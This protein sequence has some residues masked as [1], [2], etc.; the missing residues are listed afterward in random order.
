MIN[1][2][3]KILEIT[4]DGEL[5]THAKYYI[6]ANNEDINVETEGNWWFSDKI[7]NIPLSD[8]KEEDIVSWIEKEATVNGVCHITN[9]LENQ[10]NNLK[11]NFCSIY[12][13]D[14]FLNTKDLYNDPYYIYDFEGTTNKTSIEMKSRRVKK[15]TYPTTILPVSKIRNTDKAQLFVFNFTDA[16][17]YIEYDKKI[18]DTFQIR[19][20][21]TERF[22][23]VDKPKPH[24]C[25]YIKD[26]IEIKRFKDNAII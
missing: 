19:H 23:I 17:C 13:E 20:F 5:I 2:I 8:V 18:F 25:I 10:L 1:Y 14:D 4:T 9:N 11:N 7:L 16:C 21:T 3:W 12:G 22:G 26:L 24:Y 15:N 6:V